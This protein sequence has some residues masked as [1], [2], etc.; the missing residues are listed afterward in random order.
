MRGRVTVGDIHQNV[1]K[2]FLP[3][4]GKRIRK[5]SKDPLKAGGLKNSH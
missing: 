3:Q 1:V 5:V 4:K 2:I